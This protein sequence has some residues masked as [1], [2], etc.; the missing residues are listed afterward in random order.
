MSDE[1]QRRPWSE[2]PDEDAESRLPELEAA[3]ASAKLT[4]TEAARRLLA[5]LDAGGSRGVRSAKSPRR[6]RTA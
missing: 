4:P 2:G 5:L 1:W 6:A 3:V